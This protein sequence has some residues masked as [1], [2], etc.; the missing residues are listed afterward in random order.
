MHRFFRSRVLGNKPITA[1]YRLLAVEAPAGSVVPKPG[2]FYMI[3]PGPGYDPLL[4]RPFS[5]FRYSGDGLEFLIRIRGK[6]TIALSRLRRGD[7]IECIG[8]LGKAYPPPSGD[9]IVV[10]GGVG[11]A[12]L[13]PLLEAEGRRAHLFYGAVNRQ[14]LVM[15]SR[16]RGLV[17]KTTIATDDGSKGVRGTITEALER[18]LGEPGEHPSLP[19]VYACGP[20]PMLRAL[21]GVLS[22]RGITC[23]ASL[24]ERMACGIGACLGCVVPM[25]GGLKRVCMEGPVFKLE[26]VVW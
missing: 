5:I 25:T 13:F 20:A 23:Y 7:G 22:G 14:H 10:A 26:D 2:Q 21:S 9:F 6:G 15:L 8:P 1:H 11:I 3:Q 4:K 24:E 16:L 18:S 17:R 19:V 12:S